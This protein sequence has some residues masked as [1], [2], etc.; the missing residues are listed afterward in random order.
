VDTNFQTRP[1]A[2]EYAAY[3]GR[4]IDQVPAED[5]LGVL[6]GGLIET[7]AWLR[8]LPPERASYRYA[9]DKW[10]VR[11]VVGHVVDTERVF[12]NRAF[13][14][15]RADT[16]PIP[17]MDQDEY[18]R[19]AGFEGRALSSLIDEFERL[20]K[21]NLELFRS[22]GETELARR[23]TA[24]GYEVSVRAL[25]FILAGHERHHRRILQ[26]RYV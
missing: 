25:L 7:A 16:Q 17:G 18:V 12:A 19:H 21:A 26:E 23:G 3:Y 14:F 20:R 8:S 6:S 9:P 2:D 4:Y 24:S 13:R 1:A 5:V 11:E 15:A 10:T 22:F